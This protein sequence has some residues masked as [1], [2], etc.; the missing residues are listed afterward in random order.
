M[1][2]VNTNNKTLKTLKIGEKACISGIKS[3]NT[4]LRHRL[5]SLGLTAGREIHVTRIAPFGGTIG[6]HLMGFSLALRTSEAEAI[7]V[8]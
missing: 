1:T 8:A 4:T 5:L 3:T 6:I 7:S 2:P